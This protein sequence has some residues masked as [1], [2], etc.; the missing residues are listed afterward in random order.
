[1]HG[2][3]AF[4]GQGIWAETLNMSGVPGYTV[5]GSISIIVN[6]LI[7]FTTTPQD[8]RFVAFSSDLAKR[9]PI[10]IFHVNAEDPDAV[11]RVGRMALDYRYAFGTPV[12]MDLIGY[13]RHGHS[14]VDD[15]T[16][17]QPLRYRKIE[18][19]PAHL[20]KS[21]RK[22]PAIDAAADRRAGAR[23]TGRGAKAGARTREKARRCADCHAIGTIITAAATTRRWKWT[24]RLPQETIDGARANRSRAIPTDFT[25]TPK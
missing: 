20:G 1:M 12:V 17:T 19:H 3:A 15:P 2:D 16:I 22:K 10:P 18:A 11:V 5:G 8:M 24:R 9:L 21:T 13:R 7:G 6:N 14:E 23:R 4:A 25:F